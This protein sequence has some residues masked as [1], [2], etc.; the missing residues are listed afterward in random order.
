MA[1]IEKRTTKS[2]EIT[3]RVSIRKKGRE[4]YKTFHDLEA[5]KLYAYYKE[6]LITNMENFEVPIEKRISLNDILELKQKTI[7][8]SNLRE[9][10]DFNFNKNKLS[11]LF[12]NKIFYIDISYDEWLACAKALLDSYV[13]RGGKTERGKRKMSPHTLRKIFAHASSAVNHAKEMGIPLENHPLNVMQTFITPLI[14][15]MKEI[16]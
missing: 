2:G 4:I 7:D 8:E 13:Y 16:E 3:Y 9:I 10:S 15:N 11:E 6:N 5:G 1:S 12:K 14:K